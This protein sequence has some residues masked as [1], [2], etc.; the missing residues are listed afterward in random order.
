MAHSLPPGERLRRR[1]IVERTNE[2]YAALK[3]DP[4]AWRQALAER[5]EWDATLNDGLDDDPYP[6]GHRR[7]GP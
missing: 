3:A 7:N 6:I 4:A 1:L 5:E 2:G